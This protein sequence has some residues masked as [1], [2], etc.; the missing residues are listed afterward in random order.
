MDTIKL[1]STLVW[2]PSNQ[3]Y[4]RKTVTTTRLSPVL[5][6]PS[7]MSEQC[8]DLGFNGWNKKGGNQQE[9]GRV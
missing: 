3:L 5:A 1:R 4:E 2:I 7:S 8:V 6:H 9:P